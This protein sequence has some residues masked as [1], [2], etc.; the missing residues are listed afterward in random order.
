MKSEEFELFDGINR[1]TAVTSGQGLLLG[2]FSIGHSD[3]AI[4]WRISLSE[5]G[6]CVGF[7]KA[8]QAHFEMVR[9][10]LNL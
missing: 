9:T 7:N 6:F 3:R 10:S 5:S 2:I 1:E 4:L 8:Q